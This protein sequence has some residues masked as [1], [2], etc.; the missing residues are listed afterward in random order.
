MSDDSTAML[1]GAD[2]RDTATARKYFDAG[3]AAEQSGDRL[4]AIEQYEAAYTADPDD[5]ENCFRLAYNLDLVGE[6]DEALH[7]Y[8]ECAKQE[9]AP[10][11]ALINLAV[12]Y[13]DRGKYA[14]AERCVRQV[15]A[16]DPN[17]GRARLYI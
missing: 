15:L 12:A 13:E 11:N 10:L 16:T 17:H 4:A 2:I 3:Y 8:E 1:D 5:A 6:E 14:Q 9:K 7:L